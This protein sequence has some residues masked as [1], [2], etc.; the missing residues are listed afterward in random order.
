MDQREV[1]HE[2]LPP[3]NMRLLSPNQKIETILDSRGLV[4]FVATARAVKA[5]IRPEYDF[6]QASGFFDEHHLQ[7]PRD[8][9]NFD[10]PGGGSAAEFDNL[11]ISRAKLPRVFHNWLHH[12]T[13]PP[14]LPDPEVMQYRIDAQ[15]VALSLLSTVR[16]GKRRERSQHRRHISDSE[17]RRNLMRYL[18]EF[19]TQVERAD[20]IPPDFQLLPL[21]QLRRI[22]TVEDMFKIGAALGKLAVPMSVKTILLTA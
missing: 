22:N 4:D 6:I 10:L 13:E 19:E 21:N 11:A 5:T 17:I 2:N 7:W 14:P 9:Y 8:S 20:R 16:A 12:V 18:E 1:N 15:R 3:E